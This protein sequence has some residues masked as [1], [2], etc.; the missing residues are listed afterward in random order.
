MPRINS[1]Q[2][3]SLGDVN[4]QNRLRTEALNGD[5]LWVLTPSTLTPPPTSIA[6]TR[7]VAIEVQ[8]AAGETHEWLNVV[9]PNGLDIS[10]NSVAG[11][12]TIPSTTLTIIAGK[13]KVIVSGDAQDWLTTERDQLTVLSYTGFAGQTIVINASLETF[14]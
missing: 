4:K 9:I 10:D 14:T 2:S 6:W 8:N 7:E 1:E 11:T 3:H 12:A 5:I 13:A